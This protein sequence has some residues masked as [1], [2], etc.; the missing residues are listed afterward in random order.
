[1][2]NDKISLEEKSRDYQN[3][4]FILLITTFMMGIAA[5]MLGMQNSDLNVELATTKLEVSALQS[6]AGN[7]VVYKDVV[8]APF[9]RWVTVY[10][11]DGVHDST[12]RVLM[13]DA[14]AV[15]AP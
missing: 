6:E 11:N 14:P 15:V 8:Q 3:S 7:C 13:C 10:A 2:D 1:M 12:K 4:A 9:C 5:C